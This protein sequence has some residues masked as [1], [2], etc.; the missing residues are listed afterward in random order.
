VQ[1]WGWSWTWT[2]W[3]SKVGW[4]QHCPTNWLFCIPEGP[5]RHV[6]LYH[7]GVVGVSIVMGLPWV[8]IFT[9]WLCPTAW[10]SIQHPWGLGWGF[11]TA[12]GPVPQWGGWGQHCHG[13]AM[14]QHRYGF[15]TGSAALW[16]GFTQHHGHCSNILYQREKSFLLS[17]VYKNTAQIPPAPSSADLHHHLPPSRSLISS[18]RSY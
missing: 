8:S 17:M 4:G 6:A 3:K 13:L 11:A 7:D 14:G 15:A 18:K 10:P 5:L 2:C 9:G 12:H 16:G 1:G